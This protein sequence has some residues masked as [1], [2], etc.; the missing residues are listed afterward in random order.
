M[1]IS[2]YK[3][4]NII[5]SEKAELLCSFNK[6]NILRS[7][8]NLCKLNGYSRNFIKTIQIGGELYVFN[9]KRA[10][11]SRRESS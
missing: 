3:S 10:V 6:K 9:I 7:F 8:P 2:L 5:L 11:R 4:K 1:I